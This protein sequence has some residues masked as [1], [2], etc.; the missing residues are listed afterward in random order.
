MRPFC[1]Q[2]PR[3]TQWCVWLGAEEQRPA[4]ARASKRAGLG[5]G[6]L[7]VDMAK[8]A[9][10]EAAAD[11]PPRAPTTQAQPPEAGAPQAAMHRPQPRAPPDIYVAVATLQNLKARFPSFQPRWPC[12]GES[13]APHGRR[14]CRPSKIGSTRPLAAMEKVERAPQ[15]KP[16][17]TPVA[18]NSSRGRRANK[19]PHA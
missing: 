10:P 17:V 19:R 12:N 7:R 4:A 5:T 1:S 13:F 9:E 18:G 16:R 15:V 8:A 14:R 11:T 6:S 2:R 3:R